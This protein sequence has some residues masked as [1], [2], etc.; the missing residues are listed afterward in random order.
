MSSL[1]LSLRPN[2]GNNNGT[3]PSPPQNGLLM[4]PLEQQQVTDDCESSSSET[5]QSCSNS[6]H[7]KPEEKLGVTLLAVIV[8]YSVSGGPFGVEASVRAAGNFY[9]LLGFLVAPFI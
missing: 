4:R 7:P 3:A 2:G 8:F 5:N 1:E 6:I 9:T